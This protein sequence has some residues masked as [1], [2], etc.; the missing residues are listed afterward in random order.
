MGT[1]R[2]V[3]AGAR[4]P[5]GRETPDQVVG[6]GRGES[7]ETQGPA[8]RKWWNWCLAVPLTAAAGTL[9]AS[10]ET[11]FTPLGSYTCAGQKLSSSVLSEYFVETA[12]SGDSCMIINYPNSDFKIKT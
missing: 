5:G 11:P 1:V 7:P 4:M 3:A 6:G 10:R 12:Q 9:T 8:F 2:P